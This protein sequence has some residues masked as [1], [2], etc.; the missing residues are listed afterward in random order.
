[1]GEISVVFQVGC[2]ISHLQSQGCVGTPDFYQNTQNEYWIRIAYSTF[3]DL[4]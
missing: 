1:M 2:H 4:F 3:D